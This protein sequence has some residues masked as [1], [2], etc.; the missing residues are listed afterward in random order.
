MCLSRTDQVVGRLPAVIASLYQLA[1]WQGPAR[2]A[3]AQTLASH[4]ASATA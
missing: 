1:L 4:L 3:A 2:I